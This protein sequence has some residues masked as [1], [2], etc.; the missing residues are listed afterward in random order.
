MKFKI[1]H[2][3]DYIFD[4]GI[5]RTTLFKISSRNT[6]Y[7]DVLKFSMSIFQNLQEVELFEMK[8]II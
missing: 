2:H 5:S 1:T 8:K 4:S 6:S 3:T 7:V